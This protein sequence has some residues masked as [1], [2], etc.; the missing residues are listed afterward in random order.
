MRRRWRVAQP[1]PACRRRGSWRVTEIGAPELLG[2][3]L[4]MLSDQRDL[5]DVP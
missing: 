2:L 4:Q 1:G 3:V 5:L